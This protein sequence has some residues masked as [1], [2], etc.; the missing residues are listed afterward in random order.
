MAEVA[1]CG[2]SYNLTV[3]G[4]ELIG[5][6]TEGNNLCRAHKREVQGVEKEHQ[7]FTLVVC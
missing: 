6:I 4:T 3:D 2:T 1:V 7:V 5:A